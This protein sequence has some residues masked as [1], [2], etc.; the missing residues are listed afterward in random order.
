MTA[1]GAPGAGVVVRGP[2]RSDVPALQE[3][4][5][6]PGVLWGTT[7][8][9]CAGEGAVEAALAEGGRQW[10]VA[11]SA[12]GDRPIG[13]AYLDWGSG[14]W[15]RIATLVMAVRD[16]EAGRGVGRR[17]LDEA[18]R[19]GFG[20]LDLQRIELEVY[21]DNAAAIRLYERAG[22]VR[23]GTKRRN[24]IRDGVHVDGHVMAL[25]NPHVAGA[26]PAGGAG[27]A[28]A[29]GAGAAYTDRGHL[30]AH[31]YGSTDDYQVRSEGWDRYV[32]DGAGVVPW[33]L[34]KLPLGEPLS[35]L[36]AGAGLGRFALAAAER[37]PRGSAVKAID[38]SAAMVDAVSAEARRRGLPVEAALG[39]L[40]DLPCPDGSFDV[41]LCNYVLYHV[42]SIPRAI[43]E[44]ARVLRPGGLLVSVAPSFRWLPEL[45]DW[46]DRALLRLGHDPGGPLFG[47]TG[48]DRFCEEN[49]P[50]LLSRRF[51]TLSR[52]RY[53]GTMRFPSLD[54]LARHYRHTMRFK[55][56][57]AA[58]VDGDALAA[59]VRE[60]MAEGLAGGRELR[61]TSLSTCFV[62]KKEA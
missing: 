60:L 11:A 10:F 16:D 5:A 40:E 36:D 58:G 26:A 42:A 9:P 34:D 50:A 33:V 29:G 35:L 28:P 54:E 44:L 48:T 20:Y 53:D 37:A 23:E 32:I 47:P 43:D 25:L 39:G 56:A 4:M 57:V 7:V 15:R 12:R 41:A 31:S 24:A 59:A 17:L 49:A 21:V 1:G 55:N 51:R 61:V 18:V 38:I 3:I 14:R 30:L 13:Y 45:I 19:V 52:D 8:M 27:A 62:C 22:F 6:M 2:K 46:Q